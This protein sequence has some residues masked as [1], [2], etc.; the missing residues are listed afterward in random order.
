MKKI[1]LLVS[2]FFALCSN[3]EAQPPHSMRGMELC[4]FT[5]SSQTKN[6]FWLFIDDVLQNEQP[7]KS[8]CIQGLMQGEHYI[9]VEL[10]N[11]RH[12]SVGQYLNF[13]KLNNNYCITQKS[14][15]Y[16]IS[17]YNVSTYPEM[18]INYAENQPMLPPPGNIGMSH[19][20]FEEA[21]NMIANENFDSSRL[22]MAKQIS[23]SNMLTANQIKQICQLFSFEN[24]K[25]EF[26]KQ[27]YKSC[28]DKNNYFKINEVFK[29]DSDK[30]QLNKFINQQ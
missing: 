27:A 29:F 23:N 11:V 19:H 10:D 5:I 18:T 6:Y 14:S 4:N 13:S 8:V 3:I 9:R 17:A 15:F 1:C 12:N 2:V 28:V 20:D 16:G 21:Y 7:I 24:N 25:L 26:A 22:S 30:Q